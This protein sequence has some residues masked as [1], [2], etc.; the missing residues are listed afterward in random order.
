MQSLSAA[1]LVGVWERGVGQSSLDRALTML[2]DAYPE[3]TR[4]ELA[5]LSVGERDARLLA[6]RERQFGGELKSFA[7]CPRCSSGLEFSL[8]VSEL[9]NRHLTATDAL[10]T[11][12]IAGDIRLRLRP[13]DSAA[14]KAAADCPDVDGAR[15]ILLERCVVEAKQNGENITAADLPVDCVERL[16]AHLAVIESQ[17][18][19][20]LDLQCVTCG[21]VWQLALDM[22]AFLWS[23]IAAA[24]RRCLSEVHTLAW[25]YG[26][27]EA[28]IL[29][30]SPARRQF[31]L[32][33]VG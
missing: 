32:E 6:L 14:L 25:A 3:M 2:A 24:A 22:A 31:Y 26:W 30:M 12:L 28:D 29:A 7:E 8:D 5:A 18:D 1:Q 21:H 15:R 10:S 20:M 23:E 33:Q 9:R 4:A 19:T 16:S 27:S 11:E 17:A 13:L